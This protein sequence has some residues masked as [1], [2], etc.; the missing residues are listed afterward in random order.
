MLV[1]HPTHQPIVEQKVLSNFGTDAQCNSHGTIKEVS[2]RIV[3]LN[4][5]TYERVRGRL[6]FNSIAVTWMES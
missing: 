5:Y 2:T 4:F 3:I 1:S 6:I